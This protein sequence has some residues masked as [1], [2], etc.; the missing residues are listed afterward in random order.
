VRRI[1]YM[2][3][4][5]L[6]A[7]LGSPS[8]CLGPALSGDTRIRPQRRYSKYNHPQE[9][10]RVPFFG[11]NGWLPLRNSW[12]GDTRSI[13]LVMHGT[14]EA[15]DTNCKSDAREE[16]KSSASS[17]QCQALYHHRDRRDHCRIRVECFASF[18]VQS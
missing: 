17:R 3:L 2:I 5:K 11:R 8:I 10:S 4:T 15:E 18:A 16:I 12:N 9:K 6:L 1:V 13:L 7:C 14:G